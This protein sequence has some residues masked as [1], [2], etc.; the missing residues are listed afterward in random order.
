MAA[1]FLPALLNLFEQVVA[2]ADK[3]RMMAA[4]FAGVGLS[5]LAYRVLIFWKP[6]KTQDEYRDSF[7]FGIPPVAFLVT[8]ISVICL[9]GGW[10]ADPKEHA[11]E[12]F[13]RNYPVVRTY[14]IDLAKPEAFHFGDCEGDPYHCLHFVFAGERREGNRLVARFRFSGFWMPRLQIVA[15]YQSIH[16]IM[17]KGCWTILQIADKELAFITIDSER[18]TTRIG[19]GIKDK[20]TPEESSMIFSSGCP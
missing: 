14:Q 5:Y 7:I 15:A 19:I 16:L 18:A 12:E 20:K 9:P 6:W 2:L 4:V 10:F 8:A 1:S 11:I 17:S 3:N 13:Y